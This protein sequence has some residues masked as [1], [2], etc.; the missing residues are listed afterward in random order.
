MRVDC[1]RDRR[2]DIANGRRQCVFCIPVD[3][4]TSGGRW[5]TRDALAVAS[6]VWRYI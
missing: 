2:I 5:S 3:G 6:R 4:G 1:L